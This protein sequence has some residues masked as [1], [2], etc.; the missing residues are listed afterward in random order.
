MTKQLTRE[1]AAKVASLSRLKL[2]D[3]ELDLLTTQLS[4]VLEY[5]AVLDDV[6]TDNV[7]PMAHAAELSNVFREDNV[8]PSLSRDEALAN[9]PKTDGR[10]F[11]VPAI[12]EGG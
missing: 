11:L 2:D 9:A 12:L 7:E 6:D 10:C 3:V 4:Q 8:R 1:E 5:V